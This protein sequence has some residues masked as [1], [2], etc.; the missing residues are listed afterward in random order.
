MSEERK[1]AVCPWIA[2]LLIGLPV[3]YVSSFGPACWMASYRI[4]PPR[5]TAV[6][7]RPILSIWWHGSPRQMAV[8]E[9]YARLGQ[10]EHVNILGFMTVICGLGEEDP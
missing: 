8:V 7:Y 10:K 4:V 3:L 2:A 1:R 9:W 6:I 5:A